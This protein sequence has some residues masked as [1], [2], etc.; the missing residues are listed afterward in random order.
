MR[1]HG[2][3]C[4]SNTSLR[5][6]PSSWWVPDEPSGVFEVYGLLHFFLYSKGL[7]VFAIQLSLCSDPFF[8]FC[9]AG[10]YDVMVG[11]ALDKGR[12]TERYQYTAKTKFP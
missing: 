2:L 1:F 4:P 11:W 6:S 12:V 9:M 10:L 5:S 7:G 3:R 8:F